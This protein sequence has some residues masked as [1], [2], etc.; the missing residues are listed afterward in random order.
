VNDDDDLE[1]IR[2]VLRDSIQYFSNSSK[3]KREIWICSQFLKNLG[4]EFDHAHLIS[5]EDPPDVFFRGARFEVKECL[6]KDRQRT[7]EYRKALRRSEQASGSEDL[8]RHFTQAAFARDNTSDV[9]WPDSDWVADIRCG[10]S[11]WA[12]KYEPKFKKSL[13]VLVYHNVDGFF[14]ESLVPPPS[15]TFESYGFRSISMTTDSCAWVL[16]AGPLAPDFIASPIGPIR[17]QVRSRGCSCGRAEMA[18]ALALTAPNC[19]RSNALA[20]RG[21]PVPPT[22]RRASGR[23][24]WRFCRAYEGQSPRN[25][26]T[27]MCSQASPCVCSVRWEPEIRLTVQ[28]TRRSAAK[29]RLALVEGQEVKQR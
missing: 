2:Q 17:R 12:K 20:R 6:T 1:E 9:R 25:R 23:S 29:T 24:S 22:D 10:L 28:P 5:D 18:T 26:G 15:D 27:P 19:R 8:G 4:V 11:G 21:S 16:S 3:E 13:D 14:D 7:D